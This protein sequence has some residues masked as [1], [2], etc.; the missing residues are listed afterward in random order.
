MTYVSKSGSNNFHGNASWL[1]NGRYVNANNY[2]NKQ[3]VPPTPRPFV[4]DNMWQASVSGPIKK[5]RT[6]F[7]VNTEGLY[8]LIPVSIP[9][10]VPSTAF[11]SAVLGNISLRTADRTP[12]LYKHVQYLQSCAKR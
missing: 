5:D 6:F 3:N 1:W 4:N 11:Q 10:N 2:F 7:F 8:L 9:V 12:S